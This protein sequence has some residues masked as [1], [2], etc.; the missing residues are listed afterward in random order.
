MDTFAKGVVKHRVLLLIVCILL[1]IPS[2]F[3]IINTRI[4][5]DM[6]TYLPKNLDT[7]KGQ[8][9]LLD[10]FGKGAFSIILVENKSSKEVAEIKSN[11]EKVDHVESVVWYNSLMGDSVPMEAIPK[12]YLEA[13]NKGDST[14]MAVFFDSSTSAD[15][16]IKAIGDIRK[17]ATKDSYITGMSALVK[18]LKDLCEAEEPHYVAIAVI[19]AVVAMMILLD[20]W[21]IPI[22]FLIG[23]GMTILYNLGSNVLLG[24]ISYIT[25]ALSAVLQLAVTMD[26]SIFLWHSYEEER[27]KLGNHEEA[28]AKAITHTITSIVGSSTT[29]IAGFVALCFMSFTL[30]RDLGIV[31]AKGV[32]FGVIGS[33]TILPALILFFEKT[34]EK[35]RHRSIIP[36]MDKLAK[37]TVKKS[38]IFLIIFAV[39]L[40]PAYYGYTHTNIYYDMGSALPKDMN[41]TISKEK[42]M[43]KFNLGEPHMILVD[44]NISAKDSQD[45][46]DQLNDIKGVKA[47]IGADDVLGRSVPKE[48]LPKEAL[49]SLESGKYQ[50]VT[51]MSE[52]KVASKEV[53]NQL[54]KVNNIVKEYD[55]K[56]MVIG[57]AACTKDLMKT[58]DED[59]RKVSIISVLL[60]FIIIAIV[61]KTGS[62]PFILVATIYFAIFINLGLPYYTNMSLAFI[63]PICLSTI[64]LGATV[65]YAILMTTRYKRERLLGFERD[66][67]IITA[68]STSIPSIIVSAV[69]FFFA[70]YGVSVY[71]DLD[72]ISSMCRLMARGAIISMLAVIFILPAFLRIFDKLIIKTTAGMKH[73][74]PSESSL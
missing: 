33:V 64:Q 21:A 71:S 72:I 45:M 11:I 55:K 54:T 9:I 30:G 1:L 70:T 38:W 63:A 46:M 68:L 44:K 37:F 73:I 41:Y 60:V 10:D 69:G 40:G 50:L 18:D 58:S 3:G 6:L 13:F 5:Y 43:S 74:E 35:T 16:T 25:K 2:V 19:C 49:N 47:V 48:M 51:V 20:S 42:L 66:D 12:R 8:D 14:I 57:E 17:V 56:A 32:V 67:S 52:Y 59:F 4:N 65:D 36:N 53:N 26:Y 22:I 15:E 29:T 24:E 23:I 31:M 34:I 27:A 7:V 28:M 62:L 39:I 61:L